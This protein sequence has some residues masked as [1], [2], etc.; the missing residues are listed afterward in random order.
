[1]PRTPTGS[2]SASRAA[3]TRSWASTSTPLQ[4]EA[5]INTL[6]IDFRAQKRQI[7]RLRKVKDER[8]GAKVKSLLEKL[9]KAYADPD[10]NSMYPMMDAVMAYATLGEIMQVGR[11]IF[12]VWSEP[13]LI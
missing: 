7:N 4:E 11:D 1:M 2:P 5:P 6:K 13:L 10:A 3:R 9:R 8:D 12:G